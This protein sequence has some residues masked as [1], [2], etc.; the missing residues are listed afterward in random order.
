MTRLAVSEVDHVAI[1]GSVTGRHTALAGRFT[2]FTPVQ[3]AVLSDVP[4]SE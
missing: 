2:T 3:S 4:G 1:A